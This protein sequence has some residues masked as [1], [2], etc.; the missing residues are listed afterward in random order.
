METLLFVDC[1]LRGESSRTLRLCRAWL[2]RYREL[3][4]DSQVERV[5]LA[6]LGLAP[7]GRAE[8]EERDRLVARGEL[9]HPLAAPAVQF[10]RADRVL[11]GA[12]YWDLSFPAALKAYLER[13]C[14]CGVTFRYTETGSQ[15]LCRAKE[16]TYLTTA[17]GFIGARNFGLDY[18]A[19]VAE[20]LGIPAVR[21]A[22]AQGLDIQ[23]MDVEAILA[24]SVRE[25]RALL[26]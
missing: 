18:V 25:T 15:G 8:T 13:V 1:C 6:R 4:P 14:V 11:I 21:F 10:A 26:L 16:L 5:E 7:L 2:D 23:G 12:P 9:D 17:G 20:F 19:G 24:Q 22:S 3:C